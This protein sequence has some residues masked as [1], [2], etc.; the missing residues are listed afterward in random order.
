MH[1]SNLHA[2]RQA[3]HFFFPDGVEKSVV[4]ELVDVALEEALLAGLAPRDSL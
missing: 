2:S 4:L 1:D 3:A